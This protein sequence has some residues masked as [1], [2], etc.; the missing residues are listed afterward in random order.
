MN[1]TAIKAA[2]LPRKLLGAVILMVG[3]WFSAACGATAG[4]L[5]RESVS[6]PLD[7]AARAN[8]E[9]A[10]NVGQLSIG[11]LDQ[12]SELIRGDIA[13]YDQNRAIRDFAVSDDTATFKLREQDSQRIGLNTRSDD[14]IRW[15]LRLN[16]ATPMHLTVETGIGEGTIDLSQLHVTDL[17]LKIG[18]GNTTLMLPDL[19]PV[20]V[21]VSGG[22]GN[23]TIIIPADLAA[24]V[25]SSAGLGNITYPNTYQQQG[26]V[27]VSS[28]FDATTAH[29]DLTVSGGIGN[30]TIQQG[31]E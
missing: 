28:D 24:R 10:L 7:A 19:V 8:V 16:Q 25:E 23:T 26:K 5:I 1:M 12:S 13:Y 3:V 30:I 15:E 11:A 6:Q 22:V 29:I 20:R 17:D 31:S 18:V 14:V 21:H 9:I 2:A 27:Y 4:Q